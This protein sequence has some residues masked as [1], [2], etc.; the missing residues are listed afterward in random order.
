MSCASDSGGY[1]YTQPMT[2]APVGSR[3]VNVNPVR[4]SKSAAWRTRSARFASWLSPPMGGHSPSGYPGVAQMCSML[5]V[6]A[7][8]SASLWLGPSGSRRKSAVTSDVGGSKP[9]GTNGCVDIPGDY[10]PRRRR[11][12]D[13]RVTGWRRMVRS[14]SGAV[15]RASLR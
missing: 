4:S 2:C 3:T 14:L 11:V 15:R 9:S 8:R 10:G 1:R 5:E 6:H 13:H 12:D 7:A